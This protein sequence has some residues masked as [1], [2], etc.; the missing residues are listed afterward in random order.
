MSR[1]ETADLEP[2]SPYQ[3][4]IGL[5]LSTISLRDGKPL[6]NY[7]TLSERLLDENS[8]GKE[9]VGAEQLRRIHRGEISRTRPLKEIYTVYSDE[10]AE[11][12]ISAIQL[13]ASDALERSFLLGDQMALHHQIRQIHSAPKLDLF[14]ADK[15]FQL[16]LNGRGYQLGGGDLAMGL[17]AFQK[18]SEA[19]SSIRDDYPGN[20]F[21]RYHCL[22]AAEAEIN[23]SY[24]LYKSGDWSKVSYRDLIYSL[25]AKG[26]K[27]EIE[28][29]LEKIAP[30]ARRA[31]LLAESFAVV[32]PEAASDALRQAIMIDPSLAHFDQK[33]FSDVEPT[34]KSDFLAVIAQ[35][36][37]KTD[38]A[39]L[40]ASRELAAPGVPITTQK[41]AQISRQ[42]RKLFK[43]PTTD[44]EPTHAS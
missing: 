15:A 1:K 38:T 33:P 13:A 40:L 26:I 24:S 37:E 4:M 42:I 29:A 32:S 5:L 34:T 31:Y 16:F 14:P 23:M 36:M 3:R 21:L 44:K 18:A 7:E 2:I 12:V 19:F 28:W 8:E 35:G 43:N 11:E 9:E 41:K 22:L 10:L 17:K 39:L 25:M 6:F 27:S 30:D 20:P